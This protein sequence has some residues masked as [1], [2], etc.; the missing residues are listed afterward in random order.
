MDYDQIIKAIPQLWK[1]YITAK[2][3]IHMDE[4]AVTSFIEW[5]KKKIET[6][7]NES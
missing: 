5:L 2:G 6:K 1:E 3:Y 4:V 7:K